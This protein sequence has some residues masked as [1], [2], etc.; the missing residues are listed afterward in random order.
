MK[1]LMIA[2]FWLVSFSANAQIQQVTL[3]VLKKIG[4][5]KYLG[6]FLAEISYTTKDSDTSY[7]LLFNNAKYSHITDLARVEF[8]N[9]PGI[10][11]TLYNLLNSGFD[12]EKG[13]QSTFYLGKDFIA[14]SSD[15]AMGIKFIKV[16]ALDKKAYFYLRKKQLN[17]LFGKSVK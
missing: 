14:V 10:L 11:D 4:E 5:V 12:L 9:S 7:S 3:P 16:L 15:K 13:K 1:Y 17:E 8:E 2:L 6:E